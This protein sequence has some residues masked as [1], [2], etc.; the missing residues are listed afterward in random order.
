MR[1]LTIILLALLTVSGLTFCSK[2][3]AKMPDDETD[4]PEEVLENLSGEWVDGNM[5]ECLS[6]WENGK[7]YHVWNSTEELSKRE[8][9]S[10]LFGLYKLYWFIH[11]NSFY[12]LEVSIH[13]PTEK[14][15][16]SPYM[17]CEK[18]D[19]KIYHYE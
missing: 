16:G 7:Q 13:P 4:K 15:T 10:A 2:A 1:V 12:R 8:W 11:K 5:Q 19:Y 3:N 14:S 6:A 17:S 9:D 18:L